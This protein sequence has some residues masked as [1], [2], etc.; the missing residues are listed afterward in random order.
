MDATCN[1]E[2]Y[3]AAAGE[4]QTTSCA[5]YPGEYTLVCADSYGD[6]WNGAH[7]TIQGVR[8]CDNFY[9]GNE[10]EVKVIITGDWSM[11]ASGNG[12]SGNMHSLN[13][14]S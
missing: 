14:T 10:M 5:L 11:P 2:E 4:E 12:I 8:Y 9:D 1:G 7:L 6:G 13:V 3:S